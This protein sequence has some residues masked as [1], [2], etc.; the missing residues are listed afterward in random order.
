MTEIRPLYFYGEVP[1]DAR[2]ALREGKELLAVD[3][4]IKPYEVTMDQPPE[5]VVLCF[6]DPPYVFMDGFVRLTPPYSGERMA[7]ALRE[8]YGITDGRW[9]TTA[10][11]WLSQQFGTPVKFLYEEQDVRGI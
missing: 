4:Y 7:A 3:W 11:D 8:I 9:I 1:D 10:E 6:E 2:F 5:G